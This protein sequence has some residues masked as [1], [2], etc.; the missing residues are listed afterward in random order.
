MADENEQDPST[1]SLPFEGN[2]QLIRR[3]WHVGRWFFSVV[4]V[5]AVLTESIDPGT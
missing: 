4:D 5:V 1:A 3:Q 2:G